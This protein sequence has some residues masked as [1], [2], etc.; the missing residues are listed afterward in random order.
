MTVDGP[1]NAKVVANTIE[2]NPQSTPFF[3]C[4]TDLV[5][6]L[7][8]GFIISHGMNKTQLV[9]QCLVGIIFGLHKLSQT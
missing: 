4:C 7:M 2:N 1:P 9:L 5:S 6:K 3:S 8:G